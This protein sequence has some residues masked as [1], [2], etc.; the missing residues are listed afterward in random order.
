MYLKAG[1]QTSADGRM[2]WQAMYQLWGNTV[3]ESEPESYA[4]RQNLRY[5]G[6]Y[7]DRETGLH[8]NTLR[9]YD[10]DIGRFTTPDPIGFAGRVNLYRYAP[11]P[12]SWIDPWGLC[13]KW[14]N[15]KNGPTYGHTF[16]DH[17]KKL[18]P[19]QLIGRARGKGHQIGQCLDDNAAAIFITDVAKK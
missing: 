19:Q 2:V 3:R 13:F 8:Y 12:M 18:K 9:Y 17:G 4:V 5:Q 1:P 14:G 11:N 6:P 7:L 15:P 16:L 10:P